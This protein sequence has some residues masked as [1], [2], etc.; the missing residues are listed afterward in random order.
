MLEAYRRRQ[1]E[2]EQLQSVSLLEERVGAR[3][4]KHLGERLDAALC[5]TELMRRAA[6]ADREVWAERLADVLRGC[7][8]DAA[9]R[10]DERAAPVQTQAVHAQVV[11]AR[12]AGNVSLATSSSLEISIEPAHVELAADPERLQRAL[13]IVLQG[14]ANLRSGSLRLRVRGAA[15][16]IC[17]EVLLEDGVW[18][19]GVLALEDASEADLIREPLKVTA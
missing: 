16:E 7:L 10:G 13:E 18:P 9:T 3:L 11:C 8:R 5:Y 14:L 15:E 12:A 2:L 19:Q 1:R 4:V 6:G 17:F